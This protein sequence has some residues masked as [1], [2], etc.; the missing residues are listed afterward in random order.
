VAS[1]ASAAV[2]SVLRSNLVGIAPPCSR[3]FLVGNARVY[4]P[5]MSFQFSVISFQFTG[6]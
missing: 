6:P 2:S 3:L 4:S 1:A 5:V